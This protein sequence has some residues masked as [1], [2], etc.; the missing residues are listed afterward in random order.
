MISCIG[1]RHLDGAGQL[2]FHR[3]HDMVRHKWLS[4]VFVAVPHRRQVQILEVPDHSRA[5][6]S[7][8]AHCRTPISGHNWSKPARSTGATSTIVTGAMVSSLASTAA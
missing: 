7:D 1:D 6:I 2:F 5:Y 8:R 3:F 4:R